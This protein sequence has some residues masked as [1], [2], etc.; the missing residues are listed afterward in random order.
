MAKTNIGIRPL[1][2]DTELVPTSDPRSG[3]V[4]IDPERKSGVPCFA[5]TR[6]P[7]QDLWD[8]LAAG[9]TVD[10]FLDSFPTVSR[11]QA[12]LAVD[13]GRASLLDHLR[14]E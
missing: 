10:E 4:S 2:S 6:A 7:I 5:G 11:H 1:R 14:T 13:L 8:Y 12:I 3:L 9:G